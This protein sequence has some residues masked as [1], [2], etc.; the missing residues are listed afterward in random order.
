MNFIRK[1]WKGI[2]VRLVMAVPCR[3]LGQ[4]FPIAGGPA[5]A[6]LVRSS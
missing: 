6:A 2:L 4:R 3:L 1:N 5:D